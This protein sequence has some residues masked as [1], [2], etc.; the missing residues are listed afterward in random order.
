MVLVTILV[1]LALPFNSM[2]KATDMNV[3]REYTGHGVGRSMHEGPA[4][5]ELRYPWKR[6]GTAGWYDDRP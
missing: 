1:I 5:T 4:G 2:L 3:V 6:N